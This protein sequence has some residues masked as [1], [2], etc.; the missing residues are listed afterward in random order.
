MPREKHIK[1]LKQGTVI[2]NEWRQQQETSRQLTSHDFGGSLDFRGADLSK[3]SL[4]GANLKSLNFSGANLRGADFR[5]S[6]LM[7]AKFRGADLSE[8]N[9]R[10]CIL[11]DADLSDANLNGAY[12]S[13]ANFY[14]ANLSNAD[15]S[16][17]KMEGTNFGSNDLR[18]VKGLNSVFHYGPSAIGIDT[19]YK[20]AGDIPDIFLRNCGM[21]DDFV[22]YLPSLIGAQQAIQFYSCFISYSHKDEEFAKRLYSRMRDEHLRVWFAPEDMKAGEKL[23]EQ[24]DRAIQVFDRLL[25]V[26]SENSL[27]S[28]WVMTEIRKARKAEI[29]E[30][31]Q[32]LFPI[33]L[34]SFVDLQNWECFDADSG[35]D[36]A[37]EVR[38]YFIPDFSNWKD[39]DV[40]ETAFGKL[41]K[42]LR[43]AEKSVSKG[44]PTSAVKI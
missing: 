30:K 13:G 7:N 36:L 24:I 5:G 40:F 19:L 41:L 37:T 38:E 6:N 15:F 23:N 2:W 12:L 3:I 44:V 31:R 35:K 1:V 39:H 26:L 18:T 33:R 4:R 16:N 32:K 28:E 27:Q 34:V 17:S 9:L 29:R 21:P 43:E 22:T 11:I 10:S 8:V 20:S 42:D 25:L 14:N